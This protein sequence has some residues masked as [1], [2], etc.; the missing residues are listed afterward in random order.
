M[1]AESKIQL[2]SYWRGLQLKRIL[3]KYSLKHQFLMKVIVLTKDYVPDACVILLN[4]DS[5]HNQ[6]K[7]EKN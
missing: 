3:Y 4:T 7:W 6:Q 1:L 2:I 5:D